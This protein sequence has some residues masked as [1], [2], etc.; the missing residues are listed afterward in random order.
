[1]VWS[2]CVLILVFGTVWLVNHLYN[3]DWAPSDP[4][5]V[6][7]QSEMARSMAGSAAV[8]SEPA[9]SPP[10]PFNDFKKTDSK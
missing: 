8:A 4:R 5:S 7:A 2:V 6:E 10:P 1:M 3:S 9:V